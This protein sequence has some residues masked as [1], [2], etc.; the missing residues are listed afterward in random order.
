ME[1]YRSLEYHC[2]D[3]VCHCDWRLTINDCVEG[4]AARIIYIINIAMSGLVS[5]IGK[6]STDLVVCRSK[7]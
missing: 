4:P 7:V 3:N 6:E 2:I 5:L 1:T